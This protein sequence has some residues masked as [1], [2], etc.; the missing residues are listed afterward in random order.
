MPVGTRIRANNAMGLITDNPLTPSATSFNSALLN[1]LPAVPGGNHAVVT[2]DPLRQFGNPEI[3]IVTAHTG[4]ATVATITRGAYG[5]IARAHPQDTVWIHAPLDEDFIEVTTSGARPGDPYIGQLI[6][7]T[8]TSNYVSWAGSSWR[9]IN[10]TEILTSVTRPVSPY[11]GQMIYETD[12][13]LYTFWDGA[14]WQ[15]IHSEGS[16]STEGT[17]TPVVVQG[18]TPSQTI[19]YAEWVRQG[20]LVTAFARITFQ[21]SGT[22]SNIITVSGLPVAAATSFHISGQF[23]YDDTATNQYVG[24]CLG[25]GTT[26]IQMRRDG[27]ADQFGVSTPT[28]ANLDKINLVVQYLTA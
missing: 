17:W 8:D 14:A 1:L 7:E 11:E 25:S 13:D 18:V 28:I 19:T 3:V 2:L 27:V 20:R 4:A 24:Y 12:T 5:T 9:R 6:Y 26:A 21:S 22:A 23:L 16:W 15:E 10:Y